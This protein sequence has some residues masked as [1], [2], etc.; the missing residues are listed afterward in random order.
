MGAYLYFMSSGVGSAA[1]DGI[2]VSN[3]FNSS[4]INLT[5]VSDFSTKDS[6]SWTYGRSSQTVNQNGFAYLQVQRD[7]SNNWRAWTSYNG[8][9]W[10]EI[11]SGN[12]NKS[13]TVA[14]IALS[15]KLNG[16]TANT[17]YGCDWIRFNWLTLP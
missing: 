16:A 15:L 8:I 7:G 10:I 6:G 14:Q 5:M 12:Y 13:F 17:H 11:T 2:R 3:S 9:T 4:V 1:T